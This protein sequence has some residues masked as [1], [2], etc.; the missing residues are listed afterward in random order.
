V[1]GPEWSASHSLDTARELKLVPIASHL[2]RGLGRWQMGLHMAALMQRL[3]VVEDENRA[4]RADVDDLRAALGRVP[5]PPTPPDSQT[6]LVSYACVCV[7][8]CMCVCVC[9]CVCVCSGHGVAS[10]WII[11]WA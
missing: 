11:S 3:V 4:L 2:R 7:C 8:V 1:V 9:V 5:L 6:P 10:H